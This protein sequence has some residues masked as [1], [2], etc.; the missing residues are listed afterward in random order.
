MMF[1]RAFTL[2]EANAL[3]PL[4]E[5]SLSRVHA[6]FREARALH[7]ELEG[8]TAAVSPGR[9][10]GAPTGEAARRALSKLE[11]S[12][13]RSL[14]DVSTWGV[15]VKALDPPLVDVPATKDG[16]RVH[17]CWRLGE[18]GFSHWHPADEGLEGR[19]PIEAGDD[20]GTPT[21]H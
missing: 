8:Q 16:Q 6:Q 17:L 4:L 20:F 9:G 21:S 14:V 5:E 11:K 3:V 10:T 15:S 13:T 18:A 12:I 19:R 1:S 7:D 2:P